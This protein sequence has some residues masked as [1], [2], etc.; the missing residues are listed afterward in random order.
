[1]RKPLKK[2]LFTLAVTIGGIVSSF[3]PEPILKFVTNNNEGQIKAILRQADE[4]AFVLGF[5]A[6]EGFPF[7]HATVFFNPLTSVID[8]SMD[9]KYFGYHPSNSDPISLMRMAMKRPVP[10]RLGIDFDSANPKS[11]FLPQLIHHP[12]VFLSVNEQGY[13]RALQAARDWTKTHPDYVVGV[14]DCVSFL[15]YVAREAGL[16]VPV[17]SD[18]NMTPSVFLAEL[19]SLNLPQADEKYF[20]KQTAMR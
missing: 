14:S 3:G 20:I 12:R 16:L 10:G 13:R 4:K 11:G 15:A 1:M 6:V 9:G 2:I 8:P 17:R 5:F 19:L 18:G 7:G